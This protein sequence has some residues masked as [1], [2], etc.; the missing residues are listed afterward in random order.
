MRKSPSTEGMKLP[1]R[2][3]ADSIRTVPSAWTPTAMQSGVSPKSGRISQTIHES[4]RSNSGL[5]SDDAPACNSATAVSTAVGSVP[6][7]GTSVEPREHTRQTL[8]EGRAA[9][10]PTSPLHRDQA[11]QGQGQAE[12]PSGHRSPTGLWTTQWGPEQTLLW[13]W[14]GG[15]PDRS[16]KEWPP[17]WCPEQVPDPWLCGSCQNED[18]LLHTLTP[19]RKPV[20]EAERSQ[21]KAPWARPPGPGHHHGSS[22]SFP[23]KAMVLLEP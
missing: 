8:W 10:L 21:R 15:V 7:A 19:T 11:H 1:A 4:Q 6:S 12:P 18:G 2:A 14:A 9:V 3:G 20:S 22:T 17:C 16:G 5:T 23:C 13:C